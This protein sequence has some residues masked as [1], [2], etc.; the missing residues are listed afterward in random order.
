LI[1]LGIPAKLK[2]AKKTRMIKPERKMNRFIKNLLL[3]LSAIGARL[4]FVGQGSA[5]GG[6]VNIFE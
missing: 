6:R 4:P 5:F 2:L 3:G 1:I